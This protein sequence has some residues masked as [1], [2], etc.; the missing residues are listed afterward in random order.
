MHPVRLLLVASLSTPVV[1]AQQA[2][3]HLGLQRLARRCAE[4]IYPFPLLPVGA[5]PSGIA[6]GDLDGDGRLE[7][8]TANATGDSVSILRNLGA[9]GF[10]PALDLAMGD[11]TRLVE[12]A[13]MDGDGDLDL[14]AANALANTVVLRMNQ[15]G[16]VFGPTSTIA[17]GSTPYAIAVGDLDADGDRDV[18]VATSSSGVR[19]YFNMSPGV[20]SLPTTLT[21]GSTSRFLALGDLDGDADLDLVASPFSSTLSVRLNQGT[22]TFGAA[23]T[24]LLPNSAGQVA[25]AD[26]DG[27]GDR[28]LV[29][30]DASGFGQ[31]N[32]SLLP[33]AGN[34]TFGAAITIPTG[35]GG[36][37][38]AAGDVDLD[39]DVDIVSSRR[40]ADS[41][42]V[43]R[44]LGALSFAP[45]VVL[46]VGDE[47]TGV[48]VADL[49][50]D[51]WPDIVSPDSLT[52]VVVERLNRGQGAFFESEPVASSPGTGL[53]QCL[54]V[55]GDGFA[56]VL[57]CTTTPGGGLSIQRGVGGGVLAPVQELPGPSTA[58][59]IGAWD[60][61]ADGD[62]DLG[63]MELGFLHQYENLGGGSFGAPSVVD[64]GTQARHM[65]VGDVDGDGDMDLVS[66][67]QNLHTVFVIER[68][69]GSYLAP[70]AYN[71][72]GLP[73][74][75]R[76]M[77]FDGDGRLDILTSQFASPPGLFYQLNLGGLAFG[78]V[79]ELATLP[80]GPVEVFA[81]YVDLDRDGD[82]DFL[83]TGGRGFLNLG[84]GTVSAALLF[85]PHGIFDLPEAADVDRDGDLDVLM[86]ET[87]SLNAPLVRWHVYANQAG[88]WT[89]TRSFG[90]R[91]V[92]GSLAD[93]DGDGDVD[94]VYGPTGSTVYVSR[95]L[96]R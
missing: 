7:I 26:F 35:T 90:G 86:P 60:F 32:G 38:V 51:G 30:G 68:A 18:V 47:P 52:S 40:L 80:I 41:L 43:T 22:G 50:G 34:G 23:A 13:D 2:G 67:N 19:I 82:L 66:T 6:C 36:Q 71:T 4:P 94:F 87:A 27:D 17:P 5:A 77:D 78:P 1:L 83:L 20:F 44:N 70:I 63:S 61:D 15:G 57:R 11:S 25:I 69:G 62:L 3:P 39:G 64:V 72:P 54:D 92:R 48:A 24:Y 93:F 42:T 55:T 9:S 85:P 81:R 53:T 16:L 73:G 45:P 49:N 65:D 58:V 74:S 8:V 10:A 56:D 84:G 76:L 95:S 31:S 96:C 33:N 12:L 89:E 59:T 79:T 28:D 14:L 37:Y 29:I 46:P 21:G 88:T 75:I 91:N